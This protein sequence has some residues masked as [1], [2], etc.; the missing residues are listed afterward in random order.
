ML[1]NQTK[2]VIPLS[3]EIDKESCLCLVFSPYE[4]I[5][6][7]MLESCTSKSVTTTVFAK[8]P[9]IPEKQIFI[10]GDIYNSI[11]S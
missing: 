11:K 4:Y 8:Q 6:C 7:F 2:I 9:D 1:P 5:N 10:V 3:N